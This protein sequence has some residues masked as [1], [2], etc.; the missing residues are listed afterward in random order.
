MKSKIPFAL[1][2]LTFLL[3]A[4]C[5][6]QEEP[7][8]KEGM[9]P[10]AILAPQQYTPL[11]SI[12]WIPCHQ[13]E[14]NL[15]D[16]IRIAPL[17]DGTL[18]LLSQ[19]QKTAYRIDLQGNV[20][21][22]WGGGGEEE[23]LF[24]H[25]QGLAVSPDDL[26]YIIES[27]PTR[28]QIFKPDG[29]FVDTFKEYLGMI[30][31]TFAPDGDIYCAPYVLLFRPDMQPAR[32]WVFTPLGGLKKSFPMPRETDFPEMNSGL[33]M[34]PV[35]IG[36]HVYLGDVSN[37]A[38]QVFSLD[39][40]FEREF[41]VDDP[42]FAQRVQAYREKAKAAP[43]GRPIQ[44]VP[45]FGRSMCRKIAALEGDL[46]FNVALDVPG[47]EFLRVN[48]DGNVVC[49]YFIETDKKTGLFD[50]VV[51]HDDAGPLFA[52]IKVGEQRGILFLK[53]LEN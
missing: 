14:L 46:L 53:P 31:F 19:T 24:G 11:Q 21:A 26:I 13:P 35:L 28:G 23:G 9:P 30:N 33:P 18:V 44:G 16:F 22:S 51:L 37:T 41:E 47:L 4:F 8:K 40:A 5:P 45:I 43:A 49:S 42:R 17:S 52:C 38:I 39:G 34:T 15:P 2:A 10:D 1:L 48:T 6:A 20:L 27:Q 7:A 50:F 25:A 29:T 3:P 32:L 12:G 36:G